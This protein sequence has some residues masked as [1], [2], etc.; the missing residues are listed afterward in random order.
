[1]KKDEVQTPGLDEQVSNEKK[2]FESFKLDMVYG[3]EALCLLANRKRMDLDNYIHSKVG[4]KQYKEDVV[5]YL[6]TIK[7]HLRKRINHLDS[8]GTEIFVDDNIDYIFASKVDDTISGV[9]AFYYDI[10]GYKRLATFTFEYLN[11]ALPE[12]SVNTFA[13]T[14]IF[15][16]PYN[17]MFHDVYDMTKKCDTHLDLWNTLKNSCIKVCEIKQYRDC[18]YW[19]DEVSM[20]CSSPFLRRVRSVP[21]FVFCF[22]HKNIQSIAHYMHA[23]HLYCGDYRIFKGENEKWGICIDKTGE[24]I[25]ACFFDEINWRKNH[26]LFHKDGKIAIC[27]IDEIEHLKG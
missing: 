5:S 23:P 12:Y 11:M 17:E 14:G 20:R 8:V 15:V 3:Q 2:L 6:I 16:Y 1:M 19:K 4:S 25:V 24:E 13:P 18:I 21:L 7:N 27:R 10:N 9:F 26:V 22:A